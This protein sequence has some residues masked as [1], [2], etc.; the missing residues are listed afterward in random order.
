MKIKKY[1]YEKVFVEEVEFRMPT[2]TL[3]LFEYHIRRAMK[4]T[5][6]WTTWQME[7]KGIPEEIYELEFII[8]LDGFNHKATIYKHK[9]S[10][11]HLEEIYTRPDNNKETYSLLEFINTY[12]SSNIRTK[13][14]FDADFNK[15]LNELK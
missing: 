3:Y 4:V 12:D 9:I 7:N 15:T 11:S 14:Q 5:P 10:L 8:V 1:K 13:E 2:E 6:I